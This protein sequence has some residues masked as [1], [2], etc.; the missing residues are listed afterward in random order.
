M[1]VGI[2]GTES[3]HVD[4]IIDYL[5]VDKARPGV[6]V[7][8]LAGGAEERDKDLCR[9]GGIDL[10]VPD[11]TALLDVADALIVTARDGATH[12]DLALGFLEAGRPVLVDKPFACGVADAEAMLRAAEEH[13]ALVTSYSA[14][15]YLPATEALAKE[16]R[17]IGPARSVVAT[18]P[19]DEASEYGGIF[20]YGIHP[21]DVA[22][23][24]VPGP[25]GQVR[26]DRVGESVVASATVG[27][28]RVTVNLIKP[29]MSGPVPFHVLA[30]G[31]GG[32]VDSELRTDGNYVAWGLA[33]FLDMIEGTVPPLPGDELLRPVTFLEAVDLALRSD[34]R[35]VA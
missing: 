11:V 14:L 24:L 18:G 4:H 1:R 25:V 31:R 2:V 5:N 20:F 26:T 6:Q 35:F 32:I 27:D 10:V 15:R 30:V 19:A 29:G 33:A 17:D 16:L 7:T 13:R 22:L 28:A 3:S 23:R 8:A 34:G 12:R 9:L 21:V